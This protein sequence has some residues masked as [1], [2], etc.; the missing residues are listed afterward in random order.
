MRGEVMIR[1]Q[2]QLKTDALRHLD[3][4]RL[5][6]HI[7]LLPHILE[8]VLHI[9]STLRT[10]RAQRSCHSGNDVQNLVLRNDLGQTRELFLLFLVFLRF[11]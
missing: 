10:L 8:R 1:L 9:V 11:L 2:I 5:R 4:H 6:P 3:G 7:H